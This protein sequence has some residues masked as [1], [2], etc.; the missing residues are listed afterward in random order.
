M[1]ESIV[2]LIALIVGFYWVFRKPKP[3]PFEPKMID[4]TLDPDY[5]KAFI[6]PGGHPESTREPSKRKLRIINRTLD[7]SSPKTIFFL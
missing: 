3:E 2:H 5:P 4:R 6:F 7:P 1:I